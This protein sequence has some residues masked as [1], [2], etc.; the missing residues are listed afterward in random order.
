MPKTRTVTLTARP[1]V[2]ITEDAWPVIARS[3]GRS[4]RR[5][6]TPDHECDCYTVRVRQHADGRTIVYAVLEAATAWTGS[7]DARGGELLPAA[8]DIAAAI[9]RVGRDIGIPEHMI[10][11][12]VADLPAEVLS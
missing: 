5:Y 3:S 7:E 12:C 6:E 1:P 10:R 2:T 4:T 11:E 8:S 9:D